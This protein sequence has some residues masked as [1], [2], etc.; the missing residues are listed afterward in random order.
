MAIP[1]FLLTGFLGSGK[2]TMLRSLMRRGQLGETAVIINEFGNIGLDHLLVESGSE[3]MFVLDGGCVC[4]SL[5]SGLVDTMRRLFARQRR[6]ELAPFRRIVI[7]TT[8]LADPIPILQAFADDP[9]MQRHTRLE[10]I[11][12]TVDAVNALATLDQHAEAIAQIAVADRIV[13][14][15]SDLVE[16]NVLSTIEGE[17]SSLNPNAPQRRAVE[18]EIAP[19]FVFTSVDSICS[20]R[21]WV[22]V[23]EVEHQHARGIASFNVACET[24]LDPDIV[25]Q[26]LEMLLSLAAG[27][28]LRVKG[29][30]NLVGCDRPVVIHGV[31]HIVHAPQVLARWP[32]DDRRSRIVLITRN[33]DAAFVE[34]AL[35][36]LGVPC[37]VGVAQPATMH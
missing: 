7:E 37:T 9:G 3:D 11:L 31:Q 1:A 24:P 6:G 21:S 14:T 8:G 17:V 32:D 30:V 18:G 35:Q 25:Y 34:G 29:V 22:G 2:T 20:A 36:I 27:D 26:W 23:A 15:K 5:R 12:T 16:E 19:S 4:C 28:I 10:G 13:L 33:I